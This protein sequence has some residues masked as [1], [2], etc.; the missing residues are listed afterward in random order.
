[1]MVSVEDIL[2]VGCVYAGNEDNSPFDHC[3][4][5]LGLVAGFEDGL[6][7]KC[8]SEICLCHTA[9]VEVVYSRGEP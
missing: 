1:M 8:I 6:Y 7:N 4:S 5:C 2:A 9:N 3:V